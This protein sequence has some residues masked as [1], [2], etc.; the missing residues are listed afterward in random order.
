M[1][2]TTPRPTREP[3]PSPTPAPTAAPVKLSAPARAVE[4]FYGAVEDHDWDLAIAL[5]SPSMRER[6]PP[7]EW[8]IGRFRRTTRIDITRLVT[9]SVNLDAGTA[10]VAVRLVE[11]R[12]VEPSPRTLTGSWD[13]VLVDGR[14][15][16]DQPHF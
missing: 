7:D 15:K 16:L 6:Y 5:W 14:W 12:T 10:N 9:R 3:T 11:Y 1:E 13:L 2:P 4:R 8:L